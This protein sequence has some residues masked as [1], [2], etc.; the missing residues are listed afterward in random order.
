MGYCKNCGAE[1]SEGK[2]FCKDCG[3]P[4][5]ASGEEQAP[6]KQRKPWTMM[7]KI[8][9]ASILV[10]VGA[11]V[12][13][14][15][16]IKAAYSPDTLVDQF[17]VAVKDK[18]LKKAR[19][20]F[21]LQDIKQET[22]D[23]EVK[24]YLAY[25]QE[26][27]PE[28][29]NQLEGQAASFKEGTSAAATVT[30]EQGN[31]LFHFT[32]GKK[33]L[34]IYDTYTLNVIPFTV[35]TDANLE[36]YT[37][38][39][40]GQGKVAKEKQAELTGLLPVESKLEASLE[41]SYSTFKE[42]ESLDFTEATENQLDLSIEFAGKYVFLDEYDQEEVS[43]LLV[44]GKKMK[45]QVKYETPIGPFPTDG[46]IEIVAEHTVKD[47]TYTSD[48]IKV[49]NLSS[50]YLYFEY[51]ELMK[52]QDAAWYS[53]WDEEEEEPDVEAELAE[54][55]EDYTYAIVEARNTGDFSGA[56]PFHDPDGEAYAE[57]EKYAAGLYKAG[58]KEDVIDVTVGEIEEDGDAYIVHLEDTFN[59]TTSDGSEKESTFDTIYKV[60]STDEGYLVNELIDTD[61]Q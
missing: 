54:F 18:D 44:N 28:L 50:E 36:A 14:H 46:S 25:L 6:P 31:D 38:S 13:G 9:T 59:I 12:A 22:G 58:T 2:K 52:E 48:A 19:K 29:V 45:D 3:L 56:A 30:D 17:T 39:L 34:G 40:N 23:K 24:K 51:P 20:V 15:F 53:S 8:I 11:G 42:E 26:D 21:D 5:S 55:V 41:T 27:L 35:V 57:A 16:Y 7:Q 47:K 4:L 60:I 10:L 33:F 61:K 37:V 1:L 49:T 32:K 43:A